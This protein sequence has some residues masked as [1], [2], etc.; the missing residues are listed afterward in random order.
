M[1]GETES[2]AAVSGTSGIHRLAAI[3]IA[4]GLAS[5]WVLLFHSLVAL[6]A[7][8]LH[9]VLSF[10][11]HCTSPGWL[12]VHA[13]FALSGWCI[14][15][16]VAAAYRRNESCRHF[17]RE[18]AFRIFP[19]YW[20][21][22]ALLL[23]SRVAA[24][25]FNHVPLAQ[26][27]PSAGRVWLGDAFLISQYLDVTPT[28]LVS[29]SLTFEIGFYLIAA[30]GLRL[31]RTGVYPGGILLLGS[32]VCLWPL[33][34]HRPAFFFVLNLWP[35]FFAGTLAWW[36]ARNSRENRSWA[37]CFAL[38]ALLLLPL[39]KPAAF[40]AAGHYTALITSL[41]ILYFAQRT[42]GV[43][44]GFLFRHFLRLGAISYSVYLAH[45]TVMSPFQ[46]LLQR[47]VPPSSLAYVVIWLCQVCLGIGAGVFLY[48]VVEAPVE[49]W[50]KSKFRAS[51][52]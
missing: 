15:E 50:R 17:L 18:R 6:P 36:C 41:L 32:L 46:N 27:L 22:L 48:Q 42:V 10:A 44:Q 52:A 9:P 11:R 5:L 14:A 3:E 49:R 29:W 8:S 30:L 19:T 7:E 13:F 25:P 39:A 4:R 47:M 2:A 34:P 12:G 51:R 33:I 1:P 26:N 20:A 21:A 37:G 35:E 23:L 40:G 38:A 16:R 24:M 45:V 28:L 43:G 31:R